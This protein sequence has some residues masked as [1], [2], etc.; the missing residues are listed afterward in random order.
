MSTP[1]NTKSV[2]SL[3]LLERAQ[4]YAPFAARVAHLIASYVIAARFGGILLIAYLSI[5]F[6]SS[7]MILEAVIWGVVIVVSVLK[8]L[9]VLSLKGAK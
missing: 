1:A 3:S 2:Q 6:V 8:A 7:W 4:L 9:G 5:D